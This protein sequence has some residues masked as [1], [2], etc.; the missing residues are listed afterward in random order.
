M[1]RLWEPILT[2]YVDAPMSVHRVEQL[3]Q[4]LARRFIKCEALRMALEQ[5][6]KRGRRFQ[7]KPGPKDW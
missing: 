2:P 6:I 5:G 3:Q 1:T 4:G 7:L